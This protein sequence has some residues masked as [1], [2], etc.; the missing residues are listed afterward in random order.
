MQGLLYRLAGRFKTVIFI[1]GVLLIIVL[2][3]YTQ[4]IVLKLRDQSRNILEF[5]ANLYSRAV[6]EEN[7]EYFLK[8]TVLRIEGTRRNDDQGVLVGQPST[9]GF[10][11]EQRIQRMAELG[12]G[13]SWYWGLIRRSGKDQPPLD[14]PRIV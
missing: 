4:S 1:T 3:L 5:Y 13:W 14:A 9:H 8:S 2:M 12:K 11:E 6:A 10:R 7:V